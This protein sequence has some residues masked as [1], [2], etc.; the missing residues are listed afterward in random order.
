M[1]D[2]HWNSTMKNWVKD[3]ITET[4][5]FKKNTLI[6]TKCILSGGAGGLGTEPCPTLETPWI[7][8]CEAPLFMGLSRQVNTLNTNQQMNGPS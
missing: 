2:G 1:G 6:A 8:A 3:G 7:V 4:A 5:A